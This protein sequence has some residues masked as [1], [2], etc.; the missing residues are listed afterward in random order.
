M[1][2]K[3]L[4]FSVSIPLVKENLRRFW[5]IPALA[6]LAYFLSSV[7][8]I[9]MSYG[10]ITNMYGYIEMCLTNKQPFFMAIH[11]IL[12]IIAAVIVFRYLQS[13]SSVTTMHSM[14]FTRAQLF[15]SS[16]VSGLI[17]IVLPLIAN[18]LI[19]QA[20]AKP[21]YDYYMYVDY[22]KMSALTDSAVNI[23]TRSN[24]LQWFWHSL[25]IVLVIYAI[26][27]F[28]GMITG[29]TVMHLV[30]AFG[31]NF[32][33]PAL[34][35]TFV[36]YC[37]S[38]LFGFTSTGIHEKIL[39]G[40]S[41]FTQVFASDESFTIPFQIYYIILTLIILIVS[42]LLYQKREM[43]KSGD[44]I[45][46]NF[47]IPAICYLIAYFGMSLMGYYFKSLSSSNNDTQTSD[48]YF[49]AGLIAGAII[50][51]IIGRM[52][53]LKTP[54]VFNKQSIKSFGLFALIASL[55]ICSITLDL[56]G[57]ENRVPN[58]SKV[59]GVVST[60]F[61][62]VNNGDRYTINSFKSSSSES[63]TNGFYYCDPKNVK[64]LIALH[65]DIVN[66]KSKIEKEQNLNIQTY[67]ISLY[68]DIS[69]PLGFQRLYTLSYKEM[70]HNKPLKQLYES[71]E[72]KNYFSFNN[73][74]YE[75]MNRMTLS[76]IYFYDDAAASNLIITDTNKIS[77][78]LDAME[79]DFQHRTYEDYLSQ[80][81]S[82]CNMYLDYKSLDEKDKIQKSTLDI[83]VLLTDINTIKW[84]KDNGYS[85]YLEYNADMIQKII[86]SERNI[87]KDTEGS[88]SID[89]D[90]Y[91]TEESQKT[92]EENTKQLIIT[93]KKQIE[94]ILNTYYSTQ[95][96]FDK[97]YEGYIVFKQM[98]GVTE[99]HSDSIYYDFDTAPDFIS[100]YFK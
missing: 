67:P 16:L 57:F 72:F 81:H 25:L 22:E 41:P 39:V 5:A 76:N 50:A 28:A 99:T 91:V 69:N 40:L 54:R 46:F 2:S 88:N 33:A 44:S 98:N 100:K 19:L 51:F 1:K 55:F 85:K 23:F 95:N 13:S 43:E 90:R 75:E 15:N 21:T 6:F 45:I 80:K 31:F 58:I 9:L 70:I 83:S 11:L 56:M 94:E 68:Y 37:S 29:N 26:S 87:D 38:Y 48:V 18:E 65:Q 89:D 7:F 49:Y 74:N 97:Y 52:I 34:Y 42:G 36:T 64:V 27:V 60:S 92:G 20:I 14:P 84:L 61:D 4:Y 73:L 59:S 71:S 17:L 77:G 62:F 12:P 3:A 53:V 82:Y 24:V 30:L 79:K 96:N 63:K 93:D 35:L 8:P 47:M 78:L 10:D 32:L 86:F 66:K